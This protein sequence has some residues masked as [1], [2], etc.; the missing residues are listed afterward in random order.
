M[1]KIYFNIYLIEKHLKKK[2][3]MHHT[4]QQAWH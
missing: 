4:P 3:N 2:K 1:K